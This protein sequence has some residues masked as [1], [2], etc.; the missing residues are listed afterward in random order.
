MSIT[1]R[2]DLLE[3]QVKQLDEKITESTR[4]FNIVLAQND[5]LLKELANTKET[6]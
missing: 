1:K 2:M 4:V 3:K 5:R 6:K